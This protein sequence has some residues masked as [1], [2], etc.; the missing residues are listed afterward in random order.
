MVM[1]LLVII[2]TIRHL[3]NTTIMVQLILA[4]VIFTLIIIDYLWVMQDKLLV[5]QWFIVHRLDNTFVIVRHQILSLRQT[6]I[7][8]KMVKKV[9]KKAKLKLREREM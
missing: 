2:D 6:E 5:K 8:T 1:H 7:Q 4:G 9:K 3:I